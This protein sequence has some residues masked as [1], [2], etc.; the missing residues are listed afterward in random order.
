MEYFGV[1]RAEMAFN[2]K[3]QVGKG[4]KLI[5][6]SE[7]KNKILNGPGLYHRIVQY[8]QRIIPID[9]ITIYGRIINQSSKDQQET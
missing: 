9:E 8:F 2:G 4:N 3:G 6:V 5:E 7:N 1:E